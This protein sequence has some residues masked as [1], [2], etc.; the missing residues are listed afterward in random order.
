MSTP[1][2]TKA[3]KKSGPLS[4]LLSSGGGKKAWV[5]AAALGLISAGAVLSV[6]GSAAASTTYYVLNR[7]IPARTQI[8]TSMLAPLQAKVGEEPPRAYDLVYVRDH[9][10]YARVAL[11]AGDLVTA[12]TAGPLERINRDLPGNFVAASLAVAPERAVAGKIRAGD[13]V[14]IIAVDTESAQGTAGVVMHHVLVID[15]TVAPDTIASNANDAQAGDGLTDSGL[16]GQA[17][18]GPES[19]AIRSGIPSVYTFGVEPVDA[20]KLALLDGGNVSL[21][22]SGWN[23]DTEIEATAN[24]ASLFNDGPVAD[25]S[26]GTFN[27]VFIKKWRYAFEP[28]NTYI[29]KQNTV[30][31]VNDTQQWTN[32]T[33]TLDP[34]D[35]PPGY[36]YPPKGIDYTDADGVLWIAEKKN[37]FSPATGTTLDEGDYPTGFDPSLPFINNAMAAAAP[38]P[39]T[40]APTPTESTS[41]PSDSASTSQDASEDASEDASTP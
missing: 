12:S 37:W 13:Y 9:D 20:A 32:G 33:T 27:S 11:Q 7:D 15:V 1:G 24:L 28:G 35:V 36:L 21:V 4:G 22:L 3:P 39:S 25:S 18:L 40:A 2:A 30:W 23:P 16:D 10:I 14:D 6:L 41:D 29:D 34:E 19:E 38:A 17:D 31:V 5:L 26:N 8:T